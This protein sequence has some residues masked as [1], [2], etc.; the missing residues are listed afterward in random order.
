MKKIWN[1]FLES[2]RYLHFSGGLIIGLASNDWY[3]AALAGGCTA[4]ALEFKD[5]QW[6]GKPDWVD[7]VITVAGVALGYSLRICVLKCC[8]L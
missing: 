8:G 3:C 4:G 5:Y 6:G 1:W 2:N 7:F